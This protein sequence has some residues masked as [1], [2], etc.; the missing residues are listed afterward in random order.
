MRTYIVMTVAAVA[1]LTPPPAAAKTD[2]FVDMVFRNSGVFVAPHFRTGGDLSRVP[3]PNS[4][5]GIIGDRAPALIENVGPVF[6]DD[7]DFAPAFGPP[8]N[9][10]QGLD[11]FYPTTNTDD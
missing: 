11:R 4:R 8:S 9:P 5:E 6:V 10:H 2:V 1:L 7:R 3:Y